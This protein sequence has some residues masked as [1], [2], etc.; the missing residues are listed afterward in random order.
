MLFEGCCRVH[1]GIGFG[2]AIG[3]GNKA[4]W[5]SCPWEGTWLPNGYHF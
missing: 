2:L 3:I 5:S 4:G 1:I